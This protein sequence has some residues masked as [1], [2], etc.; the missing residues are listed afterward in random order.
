MTGG[1][2]AELVSCRG[3]QLL[4]RCRTVEVHRVSLLWFSAGLPGGTAGC[5]KGS[6]TKLCRL[7]V[8]MSA[9]CGQR[10]SQWASMH[11]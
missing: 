11:V 5:L 10:R 4:L 1:V 9:A 6:S 3:T 7:H 2:Y 8:K